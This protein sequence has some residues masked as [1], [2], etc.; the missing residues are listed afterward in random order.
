MVAG[1]QNKEE[2]VMAREI[3]FPL[4]SLGT[5]ELQV[6]PLCIGCAPLGDMPETFAYS[7]KE[8]QAL[9]TMRAIFAGPI[10]FVDTAASYGDGESERRLGI[11]LRE[12]GGLPP[13]FV[14][15]SKA[16]RD[17]HTGE[18][19]GEQMRRSVERSLRLLGLKQLQL[20]YLH[21][22][23][24]ISF[25]QAM[26]PGGPVAVLQRC[27]EE[28]LI[29]HLGV[30]GGPIDLMKRFV[31]T[32]LFEVAISHNRYTLL[33]TEADSFWDVCQQHRVAAVNAA[34]YGSGILAK[35]PSA[36]PRYMYG[37]A[38]QELLERAHK[39]EE[40]CNRY[41]VPLAAAALQFSLRDPR[42]TS[43]IV[44]MTHPERLNQTITLAHYPL[45]TELWTELAKVER[46]G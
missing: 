20:L 46:H 14:L 22:P 41:H 24:H 19:S 23:E 32:D 25:E 18:F 13:G 38:P 21:D 40:I 27:R 4:R 28:G 34:P 35:G 10:N 33:N 15:A 2:R 16:D 44:G 3:P 29:A 31:E 42:I 17:L 6:S 12:V 30:A 37:N 1:L 5:T 8:E 36:Y 11:V 39:L 9:T 26:A 43:T 45:P 7:V